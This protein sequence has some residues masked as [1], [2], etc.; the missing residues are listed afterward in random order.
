M[1]FCRY[2]CGLARFGRAG[3]RPFLEQVLLK[4]CVI[5]RQETEGDTAN[6]G[7]P[8]RNGS[9]GP[10]LGSAL[11]LIENKM[12]SA[13]AGPF[14]CLKYVTVYLVTIFAR[15][16]EIRDSVNCHWFWIERPGLANRSR[17]GTENL[18]IRC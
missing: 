3:S 14:A 4:T 11:E 12:F 8:D 10:D 16:E 2:N 17:A 6:P 18:E 13:M 7:P 1:R 15:K 9:I 5:G